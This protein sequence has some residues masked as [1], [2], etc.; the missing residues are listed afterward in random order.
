MPTA[1]VPLFSKTNKNVDGTVI[2][3]DSF[4][5][6][7]G[8]LD[9]LGGL[10]IRPGEVLAVNSAA[11]NDGLFMW[12]DK[13]FIVS[14]DNKAVTLREA[15]GTSLITAFSGSS[16]S[17]AAGTPVIFCSDGEH[18]FMAGGGAINY[19]DPVG[20]VTIITDVD[21]P[22]FVTH[23]AFLDGY[24]LAINGDNKF[25]W[26]DISSPTN[27]SA[28]S[29]ASAE[30]NPDITQAMYVVQRQIYLLGTVTTEIWFNDGD[31]PFSR[32][33]GGLIE[34]GC[35]AKYSPVRYQNSLIWLSHTRQFVEF[36]GTDTK[37]ISSRY[38]KEIVGFDTVSDCIGGLIRKDGQ[39]YCIFQFPTEQR[40]LAYNPALDDWSEWADWDP[41]AA[42]WIAY[43]FRS[44]VFDLQS[45]KTFVGKG[46]AAVIA[47]LDSNS[48]A[49]VLTPTTTRA[50][51]FLRQTGHWD[52]GI[53][54][55]KR[56]EELRFRAKRGTTTSLTPA[57]LMFRYRKDG[58]SQWSNIR[59][60]D[61]GAIGQDTFP[62]ILKR[63][64]IART[65]EFEISATDDAA[66]VL[67]HA[68]ADVTVLR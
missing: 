61:L 48:R 23:V 16:V 26:S 32:I 63:L 2:S 50:F 49:D 9:E 67:S 39:I 46:T 19:V 60:I 35:G 12:P 43:D 47:C 54:K 25:Y 33:P 38:D 42:T 17:F 21:A 52:G 66:I 27:W 45:G 30:A 31:S 5:Q 44:T 55:K 36:T 56:L 6:Y 65:W 59:E 18:V 62:I 58:S 10:N 22:Q 64:G 8:F 53:S 28:L 20:T 40:T 4:I 57:K 14:V 37:F 15:S 51:K 34:V 68:E 3:D 29:F 11:K 13:N 1:S 24:I 7:N 41:D